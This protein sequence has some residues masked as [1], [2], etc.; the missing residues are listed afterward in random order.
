M[1][2]NSKSVFSS[3]TLT[4]F[5]A[6]EHSGTPLHP[7]GEEC[8][9]CLVGTHLPHLYMCLQ[10]PSTAVR[11]MAARCVGVMS[12]MLQSGALNTCFFSL[13][14]VCLWDPCHPKY[15]VSCQPADSCFFVCQG[16]SIACKIFGFL[17]HGPC[18]HYLGPLSLLISSCLTLLTITTG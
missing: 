17:S 12:K 14:F 7:S 3:T 18:H 1:S 11:H 10:Y 16:T 8:Y 4:E 5:G 9:C 15:V 6:R 2:I 13:F